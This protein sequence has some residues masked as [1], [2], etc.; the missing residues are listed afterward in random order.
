MADSITVT[1]QT[2]ALTGALAAANAAARD[3]GVEPLHSRISI[4]REENG[5]IPD[6]LRIH[7]GAHDYVK[8]RGGG[9]LVYVDERTS[10]VWK[11]LRTQ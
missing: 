6:L 1:R 10:E 11:V 4:V 5:D 2:D 7:Y 3:H 9:L 8:R